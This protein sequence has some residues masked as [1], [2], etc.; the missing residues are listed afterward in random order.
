MTTL[1]EYIVTWQ[2]NI[3]AATPTAAAEQA[4]EIQQRYDSTANVFHVRMNDQ[5]LEEA[6]RIDLDELQRRRT[7]LREDRFLSHSMLDDKYNPNGDGEHPYF[8]RGDWRGAVSREE[9]VSGYWQWVKS[10]IEQEFEL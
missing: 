6:E 3:E 7:A 9:T 1:N 2:I 8:G 10:R 4:R 5:D